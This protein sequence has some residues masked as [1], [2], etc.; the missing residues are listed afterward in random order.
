LSTIQ[1]SG[2]A[3]HVI[4]EDRSAGL[5]LR[6]T[7]IGNIWVPA[8]DA[9]ALHYILSERKAQIYG[10]AGETIHAGDIVLDCGAYVGTFASQALEAGAK[11]VV[12][13][14]PVPEKIECLR[15][16]LRSEIQAGRL[17]IYPKGVWDKDEWLPLHKHA[18]HSGGDSF[19]LD[20]DTAAGRLELTTIDRLVKELRL[21]RVDFIKMDIEGAEMKALKGAG[22]TIRAYH[23]VLALAVYHVPTDREEIP[24]QVRELWARL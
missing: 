1:K 9:V 17:V 16:N 19:V 2:E 3:T 15:R 5:E 24:R 7:S 21:A 22:S 23:P 14:E 20:R 10:K 11:L 13:I 8:N 4:A 12:A 6:S 18:A